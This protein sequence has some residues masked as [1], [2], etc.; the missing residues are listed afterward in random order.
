MT[1]KL[2]IGVANEMKEKYGDRL[3][4]RIY[5]TD[6]MEAMPYKFRSATNVLFD[7]VLVPLDIVIDKNKMDSYLFSKL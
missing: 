4:L 2:A 6:S 7:K 5:T 3:E 1:C